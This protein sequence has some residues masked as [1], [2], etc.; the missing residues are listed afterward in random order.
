M[1]GVVF[2]AF[3]LFSVEGNRHEDWLVERVNDQAKVFMDGVELVLTNGLVTRRFATIPEFGTVDLRL[4]ATTKYGGDQSLFR[5]TKPEGIV[6]LSGKE[7]FVGGLWQADGFRAYSN[8][9]S[10]MLGKNSSAFTCVNYTTSAPEAPFSWTPGTRHSPKTYPWPPQGVKLTLHYTPPPGAPNV[11]IAVHY[12][13]INGIPLIEKWMTITSVAD[14][15]TVDHATVELLAVMPRWGMY[16]GHG[17]HMPGD[18]GEGAAQMG[19]PLAMLHVKTD[20]AHVA[21]CEWQDDFDNSVDVVQDCP[22]C[23]HDMGAN[24][25]FMNCSYT[26]GPGAVVSKTESFESFKVFSLV[27]DS[28]EL[29]RHTLSRHRLTQMLAPHTT[30][31]PIFFHGTNTTPAGVRA[32]VDQMAEV[33]FEMFIFSFGS[34]FDLESQDQKYLDEIKDLVTYAKAK[35]IEVGG[36]DLICLQRGM[37]VKEEWRAKGHEANACFASGFFDYLNT[38]IADFIEY[39][40]LAMLET[41]GPYGGGTCSATD[42]AHHHNLEDSVYRQTQLQNAFYQEMRALNV[43]VNQPDNFFFQGGNKATMGYAEKQFSMPRWRDL[44][45]SRMGMYDD[46]YTRLPTQGWMFLPLVDYEGGG[47]DAWFAG[48]EV[49]YE[50]ALAQYLGGGAAACYRGPLPYTVPG[51]KAK[52]QKWISLYKAHR[53]TIISPVVHIR[54]ADM[55]GWDGWLHVNPFSTTTE[56][57]FAMIFNPTDT[58]LNSVISV[59]LYYTG[60]DMEAM[61]SVDGGE[62]Q[63]IQLARDYTIEVTLDMPPKSIHYI[64]FNRL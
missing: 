45:I 48:N 47:P 5:A 49:E 52:L 36:Y 3:A 61:M 6:V 40:G 12:Q 19:E 20:Q 35:G 29:E 33:G 58:A 4:N 43:Y 44:S 63:K 27:V 51:M 28:P 2:C 25:P 9:T 10:M 13:V 39:T 57:G 31:N 64:A 22:N 59:N 46:F 41:D 15:V 16:F 60:L 26:L 23:I 37:T 34:G 11:N 50:W 8:R 1:K 32:A 55:Q 18:D 17:S 53:E 56:V 42:H 21:Q 14:T 24:E 54:R 30:E 38:T 62:A 7:Y